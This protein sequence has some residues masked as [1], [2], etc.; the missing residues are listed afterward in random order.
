MSITEFCFSVDDFQDPKRY[1]NAEAIATLLVR[2]L[3][4]EPGTFQ[5]HP[6]M[7]VGLY[8]RYA[9][10]VEGRANE[11]KNEFESQIEK[12]LPQFSGVHVEVV[13]KNGVY[14]I[15]AEIDNTLFRIYYD[16]ESSKLGSDYTSLSE[17]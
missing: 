15:G 5:S 11:L 17:L 3:I 6:E 7:G 16:I 8:S 12:Y 9:Y 1:K 13:E 14:Y 4:L 10:S 2:L